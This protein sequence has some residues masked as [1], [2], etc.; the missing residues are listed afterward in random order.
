VALALS[1]A[2]CIGVAV[3]IAALIFAFRIEHEHDFGVD[4][5]VDERAA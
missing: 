1:I 2:A 3:I 5:A 4:H